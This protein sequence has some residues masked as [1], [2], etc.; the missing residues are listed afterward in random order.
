MSITQSQI[1][2]IVTFYHEHDMNI[3]TQSWD[4]LQNTNII[5]E[6]KKIEKNISNNITNTQSNLLNKITKPMFEHYITQNTKITHKTRKQNHNREIWSEKEKAH[7][8]SLKI[9]GWNDA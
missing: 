4:T 8:F 7:T 2:V 3:A 5:R 6:E 1:T 9:R